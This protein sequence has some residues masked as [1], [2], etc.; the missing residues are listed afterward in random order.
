ML[1]RVLDVGQCSPDHQMI[2]GLLE[3]HFDVEIVQT[4]GPADTLLELKA[5]DFD[6]VLI[7]RKLDRDDSDGLEII[8]Q[9]KT[10]PKL[11][12]IPVMLVTNFAEH[13]DLAVAVGAERGFGKQEYEKP[14][15]LEK[16]RRVLES[17]G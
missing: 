7:N 8:R 3:H 15:T 11:A 1:K 17:R 9:I 10:D 16:L 6:L 4:H 2:R 13:Q 5:G 12:E 14:E